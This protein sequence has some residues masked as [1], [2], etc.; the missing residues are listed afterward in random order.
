MICRSVIGKLRGIGE[1][2]G[3]DLVEQ[4][5][6]LLDGRQSMKPRDRVVIPLMREITSCGVKIRSRPL[7][8][9]SQVPQD[10]PKGD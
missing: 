2:H 8:S 5:L 10:C 9:A 6:R 7:A 4:R 1:A 3:A